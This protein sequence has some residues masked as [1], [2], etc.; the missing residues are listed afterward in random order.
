MRCARPPRRQPGGSPRRHRTPSCDH[1]DGARTE[2]ISAASMLEVL[3]STLKADKKARTRRSTSVSGRDADARAASCPLLLDARHQHGSIAGNRTRQ[4][5]TLGNRAVSYPDTPNPD[6]R[7]RRRDHVERPIR[8]PSRRCSSGSAAR[9][10]SPPARSRRS[11]AGASSRD[12]GAHRGRDA[13]QRRRRAADGPGLDHAI[14]TSC[15]TRTATWDGTGS[16]LHL[17]QAWGTSR[18]AAARA[19]SGVRRD[20]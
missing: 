17:P 20:R 6:A 3:K 7:P 16:T 10:S 9:S 14:L 15:S 19:L 4:Q 18:S 13:D 5:R 1:L 11:R 8:N 2:E 12:R